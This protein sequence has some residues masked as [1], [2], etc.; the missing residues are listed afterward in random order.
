MRPG[1]ESILE[2]FLS[3]CADMRNEPWIGSLVV[4]EIASSVVQREVAVHGSTD[5]IGVAVILP[6]ILPPANLAELQGLGQR[7]R[8]VPTAEA[9]GRSRSSHA[10]SMLCTAHRCE[11]LA[12]RHHYDGN[13]ER[14]SLENQLQAPDSEWVAQVSKRDLGHPFNHFAALFDLCRWAAG[15][16]TTQ[17]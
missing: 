17:G 7:Q 9:A 15:S 11:G 5:D 10:T 4:L 6:I 13:L 12:L 3:R 2:L 14:L 16:S 1:W 8:L